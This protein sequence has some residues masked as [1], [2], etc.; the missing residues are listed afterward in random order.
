MVT[1]R[2]QNKIYKQQILEVTK[3]DVYNK[4]VFIDCDFQGYGAF[5]NRCDFIQYRGLPISKQIHIHLCY[6]KVVK[7]EAECLEW[8]EE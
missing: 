4:C 7:S 8:I 5:F 3:E 6:V 1:N 2:N